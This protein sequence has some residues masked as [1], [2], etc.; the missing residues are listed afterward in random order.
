MSSTQRAY[1]TCRDKSIFPDNGEFQ[2]RQRF[3]SFIENDFSSLLPTRRYHS[4][5]LSPSID[6]DI[7]IFH[8]IA[9]A[10]TVVCI[11]YSRVSVYGKAPHSCCSNLTNRRPLHVPVSVTSI[12]T[13]QPSYSDFRMTMIAITTAFS[14]NG[15][16]TTTQFVS[17]VSTPSKRTYLFCSLLDIIVFHDCNK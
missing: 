14:N 17:L 2:N 12:L 3:E 9:T 10:T 13:D 6:G 16:T 15:E 11:T 8:R 4:G 7:P 5:P 1:P